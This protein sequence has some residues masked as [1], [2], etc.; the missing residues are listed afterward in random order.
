M[1]TILFLNDDQRLGG[2]LAAALE[3]HGCRLV[4]VRTGAEGAATLEKLV[5]ELV[6]VDTLLPDTDGFSW[7]AGLR[8]AG[9][10]VPVVVLSPEP[11]EGGSSGQLMAELGISSVIS[12]DLGPGEIARRIS[13]TLSLERAPARPPASGAPPLALG[14][15]RLRYRR[16]LPEKV[17]QLATAIYQAKSRPTEGTLA[18]ARQLAHRLRGTAGS[19]GL[20]AVGEAAGR[21]EEL[22]LAPAPAEGPSPEIWIEVEHALSQATRACELAELG[23]AQTAT[24]PGE[25]GGQFAGT[26][27]RILV[28]DGDASFLRCAVELGRQRLLEVVPARGATEALE[29]AASSAMDAAFLDVTLQPPGRAYQLAQELRSMEGRESLP[30]AFTSFEPESMEDRVA[31]AHAGASLFLVKPLDAETLSTA[32]HQL[33]ATRDQAR[34]HVLLVDDDPDFLTQTSI[35]LRHEG[36]R[37]TALADPREVLGVLEETGVDLVLLDAEMPEVSGFDVC[38]VLRVSPRWQDIPVLF[39]TARLSP[40]ARTAAFQAGADDYLLKPLVREELLTRIRVRLERRRLLLERSDRDPVTGLL[41]RRAFVQAVTA[42]LLEAR[43]HDRPMSVCLIDLD[44][45]KKVNDQHGHL[46]GDRVLATL[47]NLLAR[48][49]R[50]EDLRCRWGGEEFVL[51]FPGEALATAHPMIDRALEEFRTIPFAGEGGRSFR[52][53]FSAGVAALP[54]DAA[55]LEALLRV[56]DRR[57]Y[58][59][60]RLGRGRVISGDSP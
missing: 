46:A 5:P 36:M 30:L 53:S 26:P 38:R 58:Q 12:R 50:A 60:K 54:E 55:T 27:L 19:F 49:F 44:R 28:V 59:G 14:E 16:A 35:L 39:L 34:A 9:S 1:K 23:G 10:S 33:A 17:G 48:R 18:Q 37:V 8:R 56:A 7:V 31:A 51:A 24:A 57:L 29:V 20:A 42:R 11:I 52:V 45:F 40:E 47:G 22:L 43:R 3:S 4:Q 32:A 41:I 2:R 6:A 25:P 15:A 13:Q 21:I